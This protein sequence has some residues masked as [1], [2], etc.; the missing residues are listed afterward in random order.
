M[1]YRGDRLGNSA[2]RHAGQ[3]SVVFS[4]SKEKLKDNVVHLFHHDY[5]G[6]YF[7]TSH[8]MCEQIM[9]T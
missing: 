3:Y 7:L 1:A 9:D 8:R 4:Y 6:E 5:V 2:N